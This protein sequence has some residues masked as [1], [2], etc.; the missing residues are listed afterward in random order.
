MGESVKLGTFW[1]LFAIELTSLFTIFVEKE[2]N[3][4]IQTEKLEIMKMIIE[5]DNPGILESI[6]NIFTIEKKADFWHTLTEFQR[7]EILEGIKEEEKGEVMM[8][9]PPR[10]SSK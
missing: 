4:N 9:R 2:S 7:Q 3:M 6:R 10:K 1:L 5:T 8:E